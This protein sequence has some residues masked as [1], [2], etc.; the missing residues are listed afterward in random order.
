MRGAGRRPGAFASGC[1]LFAVPHH[2]TSPVPR[3]KQRQDRHT[4][5]LF[6]EARSSGYARLVRHP[7]LK[8]VRRLIMFDELKGNIRR[9]EIW[10]RGFYMLL[11]AV[12]Y[13]VAEVVLGAVAVFQFGFVLLTTQRNLPL[14]NFGASLS[15][16]L[17]EVLL[18]LTFNTERKPFPF[19][20]WP[21]AS[22]WNKDRA[23]I[24]QRG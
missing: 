19:A 20:D 6:S 7:V 15:R 4:E 17:Y 3:R 21:A 16:F 12:I 10:I 11:F 18:F 8:G 2:G 14:L 13:S 9:G 5:A 1:G 22:E 23:S 24:E